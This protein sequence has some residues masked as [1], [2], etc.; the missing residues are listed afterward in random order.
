VPRFG[1][2][3]LLC[4][5]VPL[6][7]LPIG[8]GPLG[9]GQALAGDGRLK[10]YTVESEHFLVHFH[11]GLEEVGPRVAAVAE[12]AH[13]TLVPVMRYEPEEKTH[14]VVLDTTDGSNGF[15]RVLPRNMITLW[16]SAPPAS[17][18]LS[19]YDDW[20]YGLTV[21]EYSHILHLD[22][23]GGVPK[24]VNKVLGKTWAPNQIQPRWI[25]EGLATYVE[26]RYSSAGRTRFSL[27][28]AALRTA[29][30]EGNER[31]LDEMSNGPRAWPHGNTA[32]LYGSS[33]LEYV[34]DRFGSD[35]MAKMSWNF[36]T[37]PVPYG[38]NRSIKLA[39]GSGFDELHGDWKSYRYARY[40]LQAEAVERA[41][42][43]EGRRLT[44]TSESNIN[45]RY[46]RDGTKIIWQYGDGFDIGRFAAMPRGGNQGQ[47]ETYAVVERSGEFDVLRDGSIVMEQ[48]DIYR[49]EYASQE[50]F[51]WNSKTGKVERLTMRARMRDPAVSYD[52]TL[53]AFVTNA[54]SRRRLAVMPFS[55]GA[56]PR[57]IW[58]GKGR[59]DQ[60][61]APA[62]SPDGRH[63]AFSAWRD[64]GY[65]D[66][67]IVDWRTGKVEEL[68]H[69]RAS[70]IDPIYDPKGRYLYYSSDRTGIFNIYAYD[71]KTHE[72]FQVTNVL[73]CALEGSVSPDGMHL[74]YEGCVAAG[75]EI[76]E[77][78]LRPHQWVPAPI[79]IN[80]RPDPVDV[81]NSDYEISDLREYRPLATLAPRAYTLQLD[82][83]NRRFNVQVSGSDVVGQHNYNVGTT[84]DLN[85]GRVDFGGSYTY[86][87]MWTN[88]RLGVARTLNES[89]GLIIDG[90]NQ[91]FLQERL[92]ATAS[93][94]FPVIRVPE[95]SGSLSL[96]YDW[97]YLRSV[98]PIEV[99][100]DPNAT[101]PRLPETNLTISGLA[102]RFNYADTDGF[103]YSQ[104]PTRG[105]SLTLSMRL[106]HPALG[107]D[108]ETLN[109]SYR[110]E[111]YHKLPWG[112]TPVLAARLA[113][114]LR[115]TNR[116]SVA[117]FS[118]GGVPQQDLVAAILDSVRAG[119]RGYL[120]GYEPR[121]AVGR[122]M[123]L[124][125]LEYRDQ[126]WNIERGLSTLPI[127]LRRVQ[128]AGLL[129]AGDA[130]D[131]EIDPSNFKISMGAALR[132]NMVIGY[133]VPGAL[134]IGYSRGLTSGGINEWWMLL[135]G[136]I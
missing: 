135:T 49:G 26:S 84:A 61:F 93:V 50:L 2:L 81:R 103:A 74:V 63:I 5:L 39:T 12:R 16:A 18:D 60:A 59:Y 56:K 29:T 23:I 64:G 37:T 47:Q 6:G 69:D 25:I 3:S 97:D 38:L 54:A 128:F 114:G 79:Y 36:G 123:H 76:F 42:R 131:G 44:F 108:I 113:G 121:A 10:W 33:F 31:R 105:K 101:V 43:R 129:D 110:L 118:L 28:D 41:G 92:G 89:G 88:L 86:S 46:A 40:G 77:I 132:I 7:L 9:T 58:E 99:M 115:T 52:E 73:G 85:T 78:A 53:V 17:S 133:F 67:L 8:A 51:K 119:V 100:Q 102:L 126:L 94:G 55:A 95:G 21:H 90:E 127:Y 124:L 66:I 45:P 68:A 75:S 134:D 112:H 48:T 27:F 80:D 4:A 22:T 34:Y 62:W 1:L 91:D 70:D 82:A 24:M 32:Y 20:L 71:L 125:N 111:T 117:R 107:S 72:H 83:L 104:G 120:R 136:T 57:V 122:Q 19:D 14:V 116:R 65:R 96:N 30:L 35:T 109:L 130:F 13:E 15:A 87:R 98:D 106:N 11:S